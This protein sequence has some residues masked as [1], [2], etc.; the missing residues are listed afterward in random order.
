[1][2]DLL[3]VFSLKLSNVILKKI[4]QFAEMIPKAWRQ[5]E[6]ET[7]AHLAPWMYKYNTIKYR[8]KGL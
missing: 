6:S 3:Q 8:V 4:E 7:T 2:K 5:N 1:M